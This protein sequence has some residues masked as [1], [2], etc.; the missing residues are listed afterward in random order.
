MTLHCTTNKK[1]VF[2]SL[3]LDDEY[4][5]LLIAEKVCE[6]ITSARQGLLQNSPRSFA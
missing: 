2:A 4:V 1:I 3:A 6:R 5:N